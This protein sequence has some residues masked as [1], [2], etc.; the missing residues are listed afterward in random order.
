MGIAVFGCFSHSGEANLENAI[1]ILKY[2]K[3]NRN[4]KYTLALK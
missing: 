4:K 2:V 1:E 3:I